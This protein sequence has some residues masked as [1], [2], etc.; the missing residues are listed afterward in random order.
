MRL[1]CRSLSEDHRRR[2]AALEALKIGFGGVAY[3]ARVLGMSR[4]TLYS[5]IRE[6]EQLR[7]VTRTVRN[8]PVGAP[9]ASGAPAAGDRR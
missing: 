3:V 1:Y 7:D 8:V 4:R 2:Y 5:G 6:L 9:R